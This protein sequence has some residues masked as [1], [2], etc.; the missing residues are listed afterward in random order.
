MIGE[1]T[2]NS[3]GFLHAFCVNEE[4]YIKNQATAVGPD[5]QP[6]REAEWFYTILLEKKT[7]I[8]RIKAKAEKERKK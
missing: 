4:M 2:M 1:K 5:H 6:L 3:A 7:E 8:D